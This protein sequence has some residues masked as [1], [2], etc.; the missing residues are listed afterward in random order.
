MTFC[1]YRIYLTDMV[2]VFMSMLGFDLNSIGAEAIGW[3]SKIKVILMGRST[4]NQAFKTNANETRSN[5][6]WSALAEIDSRYTR[7]YDFG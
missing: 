6:S 4:I 1:G 3:E 2:R 5:D 7:L